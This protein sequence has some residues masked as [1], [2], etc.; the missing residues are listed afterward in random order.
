M[1]NTQVAAYQQKAPSYFLE[2]E[3]AIQDPNYVETLYQ[4]VIA[5]LDGDFAPMVYA[6]VPLKN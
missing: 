1:T 4:W 6:T 2:A 3:K 5:N